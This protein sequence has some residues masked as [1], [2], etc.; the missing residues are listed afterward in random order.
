MTRPAVIEPEAPE[1]DGVDD[2]LW[3]IDDLRKY[4]SCSRR[5]VERMR[6]AGKLPKPVLH[7]GRMPRWSPEAVRRWAEGGEG[8]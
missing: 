6:S 3:S 7:V 2:R 4:L 5:L 8:R 1:P